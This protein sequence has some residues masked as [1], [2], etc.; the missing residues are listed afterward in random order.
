LLQKYNYLRLKKFYNW[1]NYRK[2][3]RLIVLKNNVKNKKIY[4]N[5]RLKLKF[6]NLEK[7]SSNYYLR[8]NMLIIVI[9]AN[10]SILI[11]KI[12]NI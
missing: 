6:I 2:T 4:L 10:I 11:K 3:I 8:L 1:E 12:F 9:K 7:K 5:K